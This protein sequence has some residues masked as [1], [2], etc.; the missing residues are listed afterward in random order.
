MKTE[1]NICKN[2]ETEFILGRSDQKY[3]NPNCRSRYHNK[4]SLQNQKIVKEINKQT[5]NDYKILSNL[6]GEKDEL[7]VSSSLLKTEG[8][9]FERQTHIEYLKDL[10]LNCMGLYNLC[11]YKI[12]SDNF[13]ILKNEHSKF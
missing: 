6:L 13:K 9:S 12:D 10:N 1:T 3:C 8:L 5:L 2:C 11:Y 4:N 7:K